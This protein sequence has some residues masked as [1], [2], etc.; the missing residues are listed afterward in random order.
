MN[1]PAYISKLYE[2]LEDIFGKK[3]CC[4]LGVVPNDSGIY[5]NG[6]LSPKK[7]KKILNIDAT[8]N[9]DG[10]I[11]FIIC[12][13]ENTLNFNDTFDYFDIELTNDKL[14][15]LWETMTEC[16]NQY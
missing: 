3:N 1:Q 8:P 14:K 5:I 4:E 11:E 6:Q 13:D 2:I 7:I 12:A 15:K 9:D 10:L 16:N